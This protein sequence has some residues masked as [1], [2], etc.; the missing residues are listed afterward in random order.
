MT[1]PINTEE[2][3]EDWDLMVDLTMVISQESLLQR[4]WEM[5]KIMRVIGSS[6]LSSTCRG[7]FQ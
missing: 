2:D 4:L 7:R 3:E 1:A 5:M 6:C